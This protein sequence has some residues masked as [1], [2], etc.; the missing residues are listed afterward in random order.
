MISIL[1]SDQGQWLRNPMTSLP[2]SGDSPFAINKNAF[3]AVQI[4]T[5]NEDGNSRSIVSECPRTEHHG[6]WLRNPMTSLPSSGMRD[7]LFAINKN[8][9]TAVQIQTDNEDGNSRSIVSE[10]P[11]TER[12]RFR[13]F[14][15][16]ICLRGHFK[17][18][19]HNAC[20]TL[21][22]L[23]MAYSSAEF[24]EKLI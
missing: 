17:R 24:P 10:C 4:Q 8:A 20:K 12:L 5:D 18:G 2:S 22:I 7:S 6:Q 9:F 23:L 11:R 13:P 3:T 19:E 15:S 1:C 16:L 21:I 14:H